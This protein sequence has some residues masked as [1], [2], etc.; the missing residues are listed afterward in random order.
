M[1]SWLEPLQLQTYFM[2]IFAGNPDYF[3]AIS[4]IVISA[5][6]GYFRMTTLTLFFMLGV[7][8]FTFK[9]FILGSPILLLFSTIAG[10]SIGFTLSKLWTQR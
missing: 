8:L 1:A 7:F 2:N 6:A 4:L 5:M 10:L 3:I 9:D